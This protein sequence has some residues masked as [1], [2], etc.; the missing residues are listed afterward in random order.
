MVQSIQA[1]NT[2]IYNP[3][4][5]TTFGAGK[6]STGEAQTTSAAAKNEDETTTVSAQ[7]DT[8]TISNAGA[9]QAKTFTA[10]SA[11]R[12]SFGES[13][14]DSYTDATAEILSSAAS[15]AGI[16]E[17]TAVKNAN[18]AN[19]AA[20]SSGSS[21]S[22]SSTDSNL[23]EYTESELKEMLQNGEITQAEYD[24]EIKSRQGNDTDS[25]EQNET[26]AVSGASQT[27]A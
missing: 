26:T 5:N 21:S 20:I 24:A 1:S 2:A 9:L 17:Y 27:E 8:V 11:N 12:D 18:S 4:Q 22:S 19:A 25:D 3:L 16:T 23:S 13:S 6:V 15:S 14:D 10:Q 7:G